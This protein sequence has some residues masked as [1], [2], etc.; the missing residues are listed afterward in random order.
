V[1]S[2]HAYLYKIITGLIKVHGYQLTNKQI[3]IRITEDLDGEFMY[4]GFTSFMS[5]EFGKLTQNKITSHCRQ[6]FGGK[7]SRDMKNRGHIFDEMKLKQL[8]SLYNLS[9]EV[10][11][12]D[13]TDMTD[14]T[15]SGGVGLD[16]H[17]GDVSKPDED[18]GKM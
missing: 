12:K 2:L 4:N 6:I 18:V 10:K 8:E 13:M 15:V 7:P 1:D 11:V 14:M 16:K 17:L 9:L 5:A 3:W